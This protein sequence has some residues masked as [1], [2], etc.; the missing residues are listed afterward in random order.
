MNFVVF[1]A[2]I[3]SANN[4]ALQWVNGYSGFQAVEGIMHIFFNIFMTVFFN[5]FVAVFDQDVS[6]EKY[7]TEE[8]EKK[9][10]VSMSERYAWGRGQVN[11]WRFI[12]KML[13]F[14]V[15]ALIVGFGIFLIFYFA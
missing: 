8:K 13:I 2:M 9:L 1:K 14:D 4:Y 11:R 12:I 7:G 10:V 6:F 15:Y 3:K 5:F